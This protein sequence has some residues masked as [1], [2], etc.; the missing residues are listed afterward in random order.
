[1]TLITHLRHSLKKAVTIASPILHW[2]ERKVAMSDQEI[3]CWEMPYVVLD[4]FARRAMA[5]SLRRSCV[6]GIAGRVR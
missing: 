6:A 2:C 3:R 1:M 4:V 5:P